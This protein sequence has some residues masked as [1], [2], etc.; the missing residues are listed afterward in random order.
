MS[1]PTIH[2]PYAGVGK[3]VAAMVI[4]ALLIW[5]G[6]GA[7]TGLLSGLGGIAMRAADGLFV[8][9]FVLG[10]AY[11]VF[12]ET[13]EYRGTLG[14]VAMRTRLTTVSG[15]PVSFAQSSARF[16]ARL[17][18]LLVPLAL[19]FVLAQGAG[20]GYS[21][22]ERQHP[23]NANGQGYVDVI[24]FVLEL[25]AIVVGGSLAALVIYIVSILL[26]PRK[27]A[28]HDRLSGCVVVQR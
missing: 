7:L 11:F 15:A 16:L 20:I 22:A 25:F 10:Y 13:S 19:M 24:A 28:L 23:G 21:A 18:W 8:A 5:G 3:R 4:D 14:K 9:P 2:P 12:M 27:Q 1:T 17:L 26:S 6:L